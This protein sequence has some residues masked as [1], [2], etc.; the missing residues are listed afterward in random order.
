MLQLRSRITAFA[1]ASAFSVGSAVPSVAIP[2][3]SV[4]A[5][6]TSTDVRQVDWHGHGNY[7]GHGYYHGRGGNY[8]GH[9]GYNSHYYDDDYGS[10]T[11]WLAAGGLIGYL[12]AHPSSYHDSSWRGRPYRGNAGSGGYYRYNEYPRYYNYH[13]GYY[14]KRLGGH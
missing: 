5:G 9:S 14:D 10:N 2:M 3:P 4:P 11:G 12:L 13:R 6:Q 8:H 1:I 7:H